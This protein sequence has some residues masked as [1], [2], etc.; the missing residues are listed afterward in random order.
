MS[1]SWEEERKCIPQGVGGPQGAFGILAA[2][3]IGTAVTIFAGEWPGIIATIIS[4]LVVPKYFVEN[5]QAKWWNEQQRKNRE[6]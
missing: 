4:L 3:I 6:N 5:A 1:K 2:L